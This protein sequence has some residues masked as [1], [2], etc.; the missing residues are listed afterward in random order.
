M[1]FHF[2]DKAL[3]RHGRMARMGRF[4]FPHVGTV[5]FIGYPTNK[6]LRLCLSTENVRQDDNT[7]SLSFLTTKNRLFSSFVPPK[8]LSFPTV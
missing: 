5:G 4:I 6:E 3:L 7:H 1:S 2:V 8:G